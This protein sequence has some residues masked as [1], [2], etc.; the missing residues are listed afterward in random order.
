MNRRKLCWG[1]R[2]LRSWEWKKKEK[3]RG[4]GDKYTVCMFEIVR[5]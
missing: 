3:L 1:E 5:V 2:F 4:K